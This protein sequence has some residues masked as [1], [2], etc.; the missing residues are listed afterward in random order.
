MTAVLIC[1]LAL[2][3]LLVAWLMP[4]F[5]PRVPGLRLEELLLALVLGGATLV[6]ERYTIHV[7]YHTKV[8]LTTVPLFVMAVLLP[9]PLTAL[10]AGLTALIE[11]VRGRKQTGSLPSDIATYS[12]RW[13]IIG[14][15]GGMIA[16]LP[17]RGDAWE[18]AVLFVAAAAMWAIDMVT[19]GL[20]LA[21]MS[22]EAPSL[23]IRASIREVGA[24]EAVQYLLGILGAVVVSYKPWTLALL[25][26]PTIACYIAF[27]N[28][29]ELQHGT[30]F[31]LE[32]MADAVDL[33]DPYTGGHSR[34]VTAFCGQIL[35]ELGLHGPD[36]DLIIAAA[37][38]HDIGKIGIPDYILNKPDKLTAEEWAIMETHPVRGAELLARYPDFARGRAIVRGHHERWDGTG[39][40]DRLAGPDIPFGARL[41]AVA[42]AFDAMTSDRPYREGMSVSRAA[43][44]LYGG[45]GRE[46]DADIV[47]AFLRTITDQLPRTQI[48]E[49][50]RSARREPL[51]ARPSAARPA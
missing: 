19:S 45:R 43:E 11:A 2:A 34:R 21:P 7:Y 20:E 29:K 17:A 30:R 38:V 31:L 51:P 6:A 8:T 5:S 25:P 15:V 13:V 4:G 37:R 24:I 3:A 27:K 26:L 12:G 49:W 39:Y 35:D 32:S 40:P 42:D 1:I 47:E 33:R 14:L 28:V 10:V 18:A 23:A 16:H 48:D 36:V 44:I 9:P 41:L 46:W 22:G 50:D